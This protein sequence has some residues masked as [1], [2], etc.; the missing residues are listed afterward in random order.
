MVKMPQV[1]V[2]E[3]RISYDLGVLHQEM[4]AADPIE[5]LGDWFG[6]ARDSPILASHAMVV[7]A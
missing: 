2:S 7:R 3:L 4:M 5:H 6:H 1:P